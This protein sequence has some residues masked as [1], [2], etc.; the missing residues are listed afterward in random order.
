MSL[1][2]LYTVFQT[3]PLYLFPEYYVWT[4]GSSKGSPLRGRICQ[5]VRFLSPSVGSRTCVFRV[6]T[7]VVLHILFVVV[8]VY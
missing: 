1:N 4:N 3:P 8:K 7:F 5:S 6:R 2:N